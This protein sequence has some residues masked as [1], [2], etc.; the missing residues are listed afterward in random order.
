VNRLLA[1]YLNDHLAGAT[2]GA[3]LVRRLADSSRGDAVYGPILSGLAQE[4]EDDRKSLVSLLDRFNVRVDRPKLAAAWLAEKAGRLKLN[5]HLLSYSPLSRLEE[6]EMLTLGVTGKRALWR[7]LQLLAS[8]E[9]CIDVAE[10][11]RLIT[12][13]DAQIELLETSRRRAA[14]EAFAATGMPPSQ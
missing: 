7:S 4:I 2:G 14:L 11:E 1:I 3:A 9:P 8:T 6:L 10:L 5:G 12:R 13:A